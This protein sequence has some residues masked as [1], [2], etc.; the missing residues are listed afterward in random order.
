MAEVDHSQRAH[1][2]LG[3][4]ATYR[5]INCPASIL[6]SE[7]LPDSVSEYARE[8]TAAHELAQMCLESGQDAIEFIDREIDGFMV[9]EEFSEAVQM[10]LDECRKYMIP[11]I[12]TWW[13]ERPVS[14]ENA[15]PPEPMYGT[16][17]FMS[18]EPMTG[19]LVVIDFKFGRGVTVD[20]KDNPQLKFYALGALLAMP[21]AQPVERILTMIVQPRVN[22]GKKVKDDLIDPIDL[23]DW[24]FELMN[25]ARRA[26]D[27]ESSFRAG[28]W[29]KSTFCK[30]DG[31]CPA[32]AHSA[33]DFAKDQ[34][35]SLEAPVALPEVRTITMAE[36]ATI[37]AR[38]SDFKDWIKAFEDTTIDLL[39][40]DSK[41]VPGFTITYGD[42]RL[43]FRDAKDEEAIAARLE[44]SAGLSGDQVWKKKLVTATQAIAALAAN[45]RVD[46]MHAEEA[47][48]KA[49][50]LL[51]SM[52][53]RP[54]STKAKLVPVK[55]DQEYLAGALD[56]L[57]FLPSPE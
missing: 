38:L 26:L 12:H 4:S 53:E 44:K 35:A 31:K 55:P 2:R 24:S 32:Q 8:G 39:K 27:P 54:P 19:L 45:L 50:E 41:C 29:C 43:R 28:P 16:A 15:D 3:G 40:W 20:I 46:G 33:L 14:L 57:D 22:R 51:E 42:T 9:D 5:Y 37:C 21:A 17:D 49:S 11:G 1:C 23:M 36:R 13:I 30:R 48:A 52:V 34:F 7:G 56:Q 18:Y 10:Y 47:K 6:A 25:A